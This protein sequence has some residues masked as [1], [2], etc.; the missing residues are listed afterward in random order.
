MGQAQAQAQHMRGPTNVEDIL[1]ELANERVDMVSTISESEVMSE[2][3]G[4]GEGSV[5]YVAP[6][7]GGAPRRT[8]NL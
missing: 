7:K 8:L 4:G 1:K 5:T 3:G 2:L 6:K